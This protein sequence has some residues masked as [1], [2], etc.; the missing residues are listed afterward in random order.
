MNVTKLLVLLI[1]NIFIVPTV[2]ARML[3]HDAIDTKR[4]ENA[5][6]AA[7]APGTRLMAGA[8]RNEFYI[9]GHTPERA[10]SAAP[11]VPVKPKRTIASRASAD[12]LSVAINQ[13]LRKAVYKK[14]V[15]RTKKP[16]KVQVMQKSKKN[17][18][19]AKAKKTNNVRLTLRQKHSKNSKQL[20]TG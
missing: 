7:V 10:Q 4:V 14:I 16:V 3:S 13:T 1:V 17:Q 20:V 15:I 19:I 6:L 11:T 12:R 5:R 8:E 9:L 2:E 18:K